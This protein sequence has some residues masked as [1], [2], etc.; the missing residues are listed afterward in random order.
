MWG[1]RGGIAG[2]PAPFC[3]S[4]GT[5]EKITPC[6]RPVAS[7]RLN[8]RLMTAVVIQATI[9][10]RNQSYRQTIDNRLPTSFRRLRCHLPSQGG[11]AGNRPTHFPMPATVMPNKIQ[12]I[13]THTGGRLI[14]APTGPLALPSPFRDSQGIYTLWLHRRP[15]SLSLAWL[16]SPASFTSLHPAQP[17][18]SSGALGGGSREAAP[19]WRLPPRWRLPSTLSQSQTQVLRP[20]WRAL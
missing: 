6:Y 18:L 4:F 9:R 12:K 16:V 15:A 5:K 7:N 3:F 14:S 13:I 8:Q 1:A 20:P 10:T 17:A 2:P 19:P 11:F